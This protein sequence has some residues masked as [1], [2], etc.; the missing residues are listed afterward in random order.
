M[1]SSRGSVLV[2]VGQQLSA[3]DVVAEEHPRGRHLLLD[4]P[5]ALGISRSKFSKS[6]ITRKVNEK[7]AEGDIIAEY[8]KVFNRVLRAPVASEILMISNG[9]VLLEL[10]EE[11][12]Q[13]KAGFTS[14]VV[15][16]IPDRGVILEASGA[17]IQGIWGNNRINTGL[18]TPLSGT[19]SGELAVDRLDI[20]LRGAIGM[21]GHCCDKTALRAAAELPLQGLIL[22]S[23]TADLMETAL[24]LEIPV[25]LLEGFG[26]I[27]INQVAYKILSTNA[28]REICLNAAAL[29]RYLGER[30]EA[31]IPL[32][33]TADFPPETDVFKYGQTVRILCKPHLST[34]G[35]LEEVIHEPVLLANGLRSRVASVRL[36][37]NERVSIP[38]ANLEVLE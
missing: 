2:R 21:A 5:S 4:V 32:P 16:V 36:E 26:K 34:I 25:I 6:I 1:L 22:G 19:P 33:A 20:S 14:T 18:L 35:T 38:F 23:M 24:N 28:K 8:R 15:E 17:L 12:V 29:D 7:L 37:N 13:L 27:P 3:V 31:L 11:P 9:M 10:E 30:P